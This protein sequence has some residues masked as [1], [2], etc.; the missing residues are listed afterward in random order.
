MTCNA[1]FFVS[2]LIQKCYKQK[3]YTYSLIFG[4][5]INAFV[6]IHFDHAAE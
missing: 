4:N 1:I 5:Y 2:Q 6:L 3:F